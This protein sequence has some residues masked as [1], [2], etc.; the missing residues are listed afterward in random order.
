MTIRSRGF[1]GTPL[2]FAARLKGVRQLFKPL[3]WRGIYDKSL[4]IK[5]LEISIKAGHE[6]RARLHEG[7]SANC[8]HKRGFVRLEN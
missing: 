4:S 3:S 6:L 8:T 5:Y 2:A 1:S 7:A